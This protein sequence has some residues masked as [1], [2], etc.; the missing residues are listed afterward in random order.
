MT[1]WRKY[2]D[3]RFIGSWD[4]EK[5]KELTVTIERVEVGKVNTDRGESNLPV[6]YFKG[7]KKGMVLNVTN[8]KI[9]EYN[10]GTPDVEEWVGK[11][12]TLY[13][14]KVKVGG[15]LVEAIRVKRK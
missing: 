8:A 2:R 10:L 12:I 15:E 11:L 13:G 6:L 5:G 4:I 7:G 3:Q 9:I 14:A 1:H